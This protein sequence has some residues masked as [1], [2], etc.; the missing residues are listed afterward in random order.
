MVDAAVSYDKLVL[1]PC[2]GHANSCW[3]KEDM[4]DGCVPCLLVV[5]EELAADN[6]H[7][8]FDYWL[9]HK[10]VMKIYMGQQW[11]WDELSKHLL[12]LK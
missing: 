12:I 8:D 7:E 5:P 6:W 9:G 2:D 10:D 1:E 4:K 11:N 3:A